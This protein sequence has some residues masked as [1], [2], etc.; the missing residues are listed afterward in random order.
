MTNRE[1]LAKLARTFTAICRHPVRFVEFAVAFGDTGM[2]EYVSRQH[3]LR[4][5]LPAIDLLDLVPDLAEDVSPYA[6]LEGGSTTIDL[7][8]LKALA[9]R[10][11]ACRYFEIGAWRGESV[12]NVAAVAK[13]C[14]SLSLSD[15]EM[16]AAGW[17]ERYVKTAKVF[18][19]HLPNVV[20]IGH[21]SRTFDYSP[22]V[23]TCD[24]VFVDGDHSYDGVRADTE[25]AFR[26]LRDERSVIVWHDYVR[27]SEEDVMW[28]VAAGLLDGAPASAR[29]HLYYVSNTLCA[30]Y[31]QGTFRTRA[32]RVPAVPDKIFDVRISSRRC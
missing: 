18:S 13:D 19:R 6:F 26:L 3:G 23:G 25:H 22:Y 32:T 24:L 10:Y 21:D 11:E 16:R 28:G 12:A 8:L 7:A 15:A 31:V 4:Q 14:I 9:R 30:I 17:D 29:R 2:R 1:R 5:G 27:A 20:H